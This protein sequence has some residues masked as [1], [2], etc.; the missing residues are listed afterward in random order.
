M[1]LQHK[2]IGEVAER[3]G[4]SLRT[5][6]Y[7]EEV[8]LVTPSA[9]SQGGFRLYTESDIARLQ[10]IKRMKPLGFSLD[11]MRSL[12]DALDTLDA[13]HDAEVPDEGSRGAALDRLSMFESAAEERCEALRDQLAMAEEFAD[14]LRREVRRQ[15][16]GV[17]SGE[18]RAGGTR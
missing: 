3:I 16:R 10:L 5:I 12:L 13:G 8:G 17:R 7:Y 14:S 15:Q 6:R 11:E 2:Q 9:R 18:V 1:G 4:L